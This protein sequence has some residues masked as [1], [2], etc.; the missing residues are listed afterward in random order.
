MFFAEILKFVITNSFFW[1]F[2]YLLKYYGHYFKIPRFS[3]NISSKFPDIFSEFSRNHF[4]N[5]F[6]KLLQKF[7]NIFLKF[8][9][10]YIIFNLQFL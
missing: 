1:F 4:T 2:Q 10:N 7:I 9:E 6:L 8:S 3:S 5:F